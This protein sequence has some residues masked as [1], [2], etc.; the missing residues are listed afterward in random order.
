MSRGSRLREVAFDRY[1]ELGEVS[2]AGDP[3]ELAFGFEHPGSGPAER[4]LAGLPP[5]DVAAGA[6]DALDHRLTGVR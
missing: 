1:G 5:F 2:V 4:H 6:A 3:A